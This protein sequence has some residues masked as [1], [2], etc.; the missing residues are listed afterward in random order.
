MASVPNVTTNRV[1]M[2]R[3]VKDA[4]EAG[5]NPLTVMKS[6]G[7][8]GYVTTTGP[9]FDPAD[10]QSG[11][12]NFEIT[13][14]GSL[15]GDV[16]VDHPQA[17]PMAE[18]ATPKEFQAA[19]NQFSDF[20]RA[21]PDYRHEGGDASSGSFHDFHASL[22]DFGGGLGKDGYAS[23]AG[24]GYASKSGAIR[25][26]G[27]PGSGPGA[28][29]VATAKPVKGGGWVP[30]SLGGEP[31]NAQGV[32]FDTMGLPVGFG[33]LSQ[34]NIKEYDA[35]TKLIPMVVGGK[36]VKPSNGWSNAV[37]AEDRW[38]DLGG[39]IYGLGVMAADAAENIKFSPGWG[40]LTSPPGGHSYGGQHLGIKET[41]DINDYAG[42][43][44]DLF[45]A[46][47]NMAFGW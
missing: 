9:E 36:S 38:G 27:R 20:L 34:F 3:L 31:L 16:Y 23:K 4:V 37:D 29:G 15:G 39:S 13:L 7:W 47:L 43:G 41:F 24:D 30:L 33:N 18:P 22:D 46:A 14:P 1:A 21:N 8:A 2:K 25:T 26:R 35:P 42:N 6:G 11:G 10:Y 19:E 28:L 17:A 45:N 32:P 40:G 44:N 12:M 5:F